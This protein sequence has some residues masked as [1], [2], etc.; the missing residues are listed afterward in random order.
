MHILSH[1]HK[2]IGWITLNRPQALNALSLSM[3]CELI[4]LLKEWEAT[5][6]VKMVVIQGAGEKAFCA[7]GDVRSVYEAKTQGDLH[8]YKEFFRE[9]YTLNAQIYQYTKPYVALIDGIAM[10]GGMGISIT[11]SHRIVTEKALLAM[12]ETGI[13]L[14]PDAGATT[15]LTQAPGIMGP[16]LGLTGLRM[17]AEDALWTGLGTHFVPSSALPLFK[18]DLVKGIA[19]ED[20]LSNHSPPLLEKGFLEHH[21][22]LIEAHF[23]KPSLQDILQSLQTDP[24]PFAQNMYNLLRSKSP[25]SLAVTFR[26]L[27]ERGPGLSF[28]ERMEMEFT[29][30]QHFLEG[31]DFME[32][33]RALLI[34]KDHLP[35]WRPETVEDLENSQIEA[36]FSP[37]GERKLLSSLTFSSSSE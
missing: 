16:F 5:P 29:L 23:N 33:V 21:Q 4:G 30:S 7:G 11:G 2:D 9:E 35:R 36:Y 24:S 10:G 18:E 22:D 13:G 15:F 3:V 27:K 8:T 19:L 14:F 37:T 28:A 26:Q 1:V 34:D 25:T 20:A 17:K 31:H 32:G 6:A 12:P